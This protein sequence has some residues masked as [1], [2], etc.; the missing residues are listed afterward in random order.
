[1]IKTPVTTAP[2]LP[3]P[4]FFPKEGRAVPDV[5]ALGE[6]YQTVVN[7]GVEAVGGTSAATP[8]F[9]AMVSLLNEARAKQ[10]KPPM[11]FL[12]PFLYQNPQAFNDIT[13][14]NNKIGRGGQKMTN[15]YE[16]TVGWDPVTGLGTPKFGSLL[17]AAL[18]H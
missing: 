17:V 18:K 6:G 2:G 8:A 1:M 11:G 15:G 7:G 16:C 14:G 9:A 10:G 12:N 4:T 3:P 5:S 13:Q